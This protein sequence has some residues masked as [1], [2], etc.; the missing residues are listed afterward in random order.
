MRKNQTRQKINT[1]GAII[2]ATAI[3]HNLTLITSDRD[4]DN[5]KGLS[6]LHPESLSM[7]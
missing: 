1:P 4:F 6:I 7:L 2:A 3:E 5:I